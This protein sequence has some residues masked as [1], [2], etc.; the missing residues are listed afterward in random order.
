MASC[1][2][3]KAAFQFSPTS[4]A[5][6]PSESVAALPARAAAPSSGSGTPLPAAAPHPTPAPGLR[7]LL[8]RP[9][10]HREAA[11][12]TSTHPLQKT[13]A[14]AHPRAKRLRLRQPARIGYNDF[15]LFGGI[16]VAGAGVLVAVAAGSLLGVVGGLVLIAGGFLLVS[17]GYGKA[18]PE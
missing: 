12:T 3:Q 5:S 6:T 14:A 10:Q 7:R 8:V 1:Q 15:L 13:P 18:R 2:S 4:A 17:K 9:P 11:A 16:A